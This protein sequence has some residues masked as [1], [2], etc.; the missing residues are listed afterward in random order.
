MNFTLPGGF[1]YVE[2]GCLKLESN[3]LVNLAPNEASV[4]TFLREARRVNGTNLPAKTSFIE[5][6]EQIRLNFAISWSTSRESSSDVNAELL[7]SQNKT[8]KN[9][10]I[11]VFAVRFPSN[12][13]FVFL[14]KIQSCFVIVAC[15][16]FDLFPFQVAC[17]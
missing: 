11:G 1:D 8:F 14:S 10:S 17:F 3:L 12:Y 9:S 4:A 7:D 6:A 5:D 2:Y 13:V 15:F 16:E